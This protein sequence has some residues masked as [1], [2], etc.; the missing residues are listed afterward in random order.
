MFLT[1]HLDTV[2]SQ[3]LRVPQ[4]VLGSF[5]CPEK[6]ILLVTN[7]GQTET[8]ASVYTDKIP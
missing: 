3:L 2:L 4:I 7:M 6:F 8:K 5:C 1:I